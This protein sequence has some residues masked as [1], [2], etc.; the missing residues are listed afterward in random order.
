MKQVKNVIKQF[1]KGT[2][3]YL[4]YSGGYHYHV[5]DEIT[6]IRGGEITNLYNEANEIE[7]DEPEEL[8]KITYWRD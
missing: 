7:I 3:I 6:F 1:A 2:K 8:A 4:K 5:L